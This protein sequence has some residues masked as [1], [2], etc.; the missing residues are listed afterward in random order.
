MA[1][2]HRLNTEAGAIQERFRLTCEAAKISVCT[3]AAD[4]LANLKG[5]VHNKRLGCVIG[6]SGEFSTVHFDE[7][8]DMSRV[9]G[10]IADKSKVYEIV[11]QENRPY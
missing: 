3:I 5:L 9:L 11:P 4:E 2:T 10:K 1:T 6:G 8:T 7:T